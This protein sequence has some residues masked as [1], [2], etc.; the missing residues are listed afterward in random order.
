MCCY[1]FIT[2]PT[3][4]IKLRSWDIY[5]SDAKIT[6]LGVNFKARL[7]GAWKILL[8]IYTVMETNRFLNFNMHKEY[9]IEKSKFYISKYRD[10]LYFNLHITLNLMFANIFTYLKRSTFCTLNTTIH[11]LQIIQVLKDGVNVGFCQRYV[12]FQGKVSR[13]IPEK[14]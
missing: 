8:D 12:D 1:P 10:I 13:T 7:K 4:C 2:G 9:S 14:W 11:I 5:W 3:V 6:G